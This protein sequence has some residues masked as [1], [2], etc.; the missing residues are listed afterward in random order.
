MACDKVTLEYTS[1]PLEIHQK[2]KK[3]DYPVPLGTIRAFFGEYYMT[4][5]Q[6]LET[7][8]PVD[9]HSNVYLYGYQDSHQINMLRADAN[10]VLEIYING[11]P[12]DSLPLNIPLPEVYGKY[13]T[14]QYHPRK[15]SNWGDPDYYSLGYYIKKVEFIFTDKTDDV[16][17]GTFDGVLVSST[18]AQIPLTEGEF[19]IKVFRKKF[20]GL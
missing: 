9:I 13:P 1:P 7:V 20:Y 6:Q 2:D 5:T 19:K 4:F 12:L 14:I 11:Y 18:G 10:S 8:Q 17:T 16:L 15:Q 3:P